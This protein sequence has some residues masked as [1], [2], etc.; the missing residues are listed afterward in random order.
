MSYYY[1]QTIKKYIQM[2][3]SLFSN[4]K[5]Y[6]GE[7]EIR[8]PISYGFKSKM[9]LD[10]TQNVEESVRPGEIQLPRF[11]YTLNSIESDI[12]RRSQQMVKLY[13]N[14]DENNINYI[15]L[16]KPFDLN[17]D[18]FLWTKYENDAY[19]ILEQILFNFSPNKIYST[20]IFPDMSYR[21]NIT[22]LLNDNSNETEN[23][24]FG[25]DN[26]LKEVK[27]RFNFTLK[28]LLFSNTFIENLIKIVTVNYK[29]YDE[30][31]EIDPEKIYEE[32]IYEVNPFDSLET[33][34]YNIKLTKTI[35]DRTYITFIEK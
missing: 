27:W 18:L 19:Q 30:N 13:D 9:Y 5:I 11:S 31:D 20:N 10:K 2:F 24:E 14:S 29:G 32:E 22:L 17:F 28:G 6:H 3:G 15:M 4:Y 21:W 12:E 16:Q 8:V 25:E 7:K 1:N 34:D 35:G 26:T 33:D 23:M